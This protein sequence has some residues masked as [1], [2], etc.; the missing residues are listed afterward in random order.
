MSEKTPESRAADGGYL[1]GISVG[2]EQ[3]ANY[4]LDRAAE[5]FRGGKGDSHANAL[6]DHAQACLE[7]S[8]SKREKYE[9]HESRCGCTA[10]GLQP[11]GPGCLY[12]NADGG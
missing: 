4:L 7:T 1:L 12:P 3:A 10:P 5:C 11:C 9:T 8:K 2:W 6:R